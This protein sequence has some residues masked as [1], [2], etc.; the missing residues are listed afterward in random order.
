ME[1][2]TRC[3]SIS[4][5]AEIAGNENAA[6]AASRRLLKAHN[7]CQRQRE[8]MES[9]RSVR[10]ERVPTDL[11]G[12]RRAEARELVEHETPHHAEIAAMRNRA[13]A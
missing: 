13:C 9:I 2:E 10:P 6:S 11:D 8:G 3:K 4:E 1:E 7:P 5:S 12:Q